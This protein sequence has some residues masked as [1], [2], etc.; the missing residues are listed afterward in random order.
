MVKCIISQGIHHCF[1]SIYKRNTHYFFGSLMINTTSN[2]ALHSNVT[3]S[4]NVNIINSLYLPKS[5]HYQCK[6]KMHAPGTI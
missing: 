3:L 4:I 6:H 1:T 2:L 5:Y